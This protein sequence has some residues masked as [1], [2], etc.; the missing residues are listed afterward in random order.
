M[1]KLERNGYTAA[2]VRAALHAANR[3]LSFRYE[4]FDKNGVFKKHLTDVLS[5]TVEYNALAAIKCTAKFEI[6]DS[7]GVD[8]LNDRI[9]PWARLR[10]QDGGWAEWPLGMFLLTTMPRAADSSGV[11]TRSIEAYDLAQ[12]LA[13]DR[14][15]DRYEV[16]AGANVI[17]EVR[18][19]LDSA[20]I[21]AQNLTGSSKELPGAR[22]WDPGTSKLQIIN[23]L[24]HA[25]AYDDLWF[26]ENGTAVAAPY[27][28]PVW[29]ASAYTYQDDDQ[30]VM[31]PEVEQSLDLWNVP[32][33]WVRYVSES[34]VAVMRSEYTNA[35]PDSPTSTVSRGR[36]IVD[37]ESVDAV[38]QGTL[39]ALVA[40]EAFE[41]SQVYEVV[42]L[43]TAIMP[44]HSHRDVITLAYS[45][46]EIS[47]T[48]YEEIAWAFELRAGATMKHALR[49]VVS[50]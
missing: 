46:M 32:N 31:F 36:T 16:A 17:A 5:A 29:R 15:T 6:L 25:I 24:L 2:Q 47:A 21:A 26:D 27:V 28:S 8:W 42:Q 38:D 1:L 50:V 13:D 23:D 39:D 34:D 9:K 22:S 19:L 7:A 41:A 35:N 49:R 43:T 18:D 48:K 12:I 45:T 10:M 3:V 37:V 30:S 14:V 44:M 40:Q 4:L 20:G 33:K 11:V